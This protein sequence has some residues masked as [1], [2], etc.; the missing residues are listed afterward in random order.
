MANKAMAF[1][2]EVESGSV[3]RVYHLL[4]NKGCSP[5]LNYLGVYPIVLAVEGG[6]IDMACLL[7]KFHADPMLK[8]NGAQSLNAVQPPQA[9]HTGRSPRRAPSLG[10]LLT[11][12]TLCV[13]V[14]HR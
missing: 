2:T 1:V 14:L 13:C 10:A 5:D 11:P 7:L 9:P 8:A 12:C 6:D 4:V 3:A